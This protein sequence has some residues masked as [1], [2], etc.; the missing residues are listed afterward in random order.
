MAFMRVNGI[1]ELIINFISEDSQNEITRLYKVSHT[2]LYPAI[3]CITLGIF[4]G[5]VWANV[6]W[7]RYWGWDPKEVWSLITMLI[8][9]AAIHKT[10][11]KSFNKPVYFHVYTVIAFLTVVITYFG[12]NYFL[13]GM[14]SYAS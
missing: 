4:V 8:Y 6:S 14:H 12:V 11:L 9:S 1:T 7:G 3:F 5:A 10:S 2:M 13:G